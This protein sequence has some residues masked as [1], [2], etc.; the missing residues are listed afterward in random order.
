MPGQQIKKGTTYVDYP[1]PGTNQVTAANLNAHVDN[2][3]LLPGA[4]S[5]QPTSTPEEGDY[6]I[7][8]RTGDLFK[9]TLQSI[10]DLFA[11]IFLPLAGGT[12][13]GP[14]VLV[15]STPSTAATAASKG[16]VD[17]TAAATVLS[18]QIVMW[19]TSIV[20]SGWLECN[21]QST[22]G[23]PNLIALFGTNLPDLR[24][25]F[26]RGWSNDR[27]TV[28]YPRQ[29]L[30]S[31]AQD[32]QS[33]THSY[34]I[35][36]ATSSSGAGGTGSGLIPLQSSSTTGSTGGTET[37]PRNVALMFIVKT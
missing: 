6:V 28:D 31:E 10:R 21:G 37:R 7:A 2:A 15:N 29:I 30:S 27:T 4:I 12:M 32:I 22:A 18:G 23:Y 16:Y 8:E 36:N 26:V 20:P 1:T 3:E 11:S 9:Y 24:G 34:V 35:T 33:H 13:T 5:A 14:L 17:A 19:G 25:E